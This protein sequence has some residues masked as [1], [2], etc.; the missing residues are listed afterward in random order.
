MTIRS[1]RTEELPVIME[2]ANR[3]WRPINEAYRAEFGDEL[4]TI[5]FPTPDTRA[6]ENV[7]RD[8]E[9]RP[10]QTIVVEHEGHIVGFCNYWMEEPQKI[11]VIGYNAADP[12][13]G[14]KGIGQQMY[15]W[16]LN[17]FRRRGMR[18][19]RVLTGLDS[20]HARARRAYERAGFNISHGTVT[21]YTRL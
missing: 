9:A 4:F 11:G 20:G 5:L 1:Y 18:Y 12:D 6:G 3:A 15:A 10:D 19:A 8:I 14:L 2:I 16:V 13:S 17:E 7:R 21:L